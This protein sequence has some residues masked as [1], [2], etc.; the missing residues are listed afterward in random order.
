MCSVTSTRVQHEE[1]RGEVYLSDRVARVDQLV[2][3]VVDERLT[4]SI[5]FTY[6]CSSKSACQ[7]LS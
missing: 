2:V 3:M 7:C 6:L 1:R 4:F 5:Q